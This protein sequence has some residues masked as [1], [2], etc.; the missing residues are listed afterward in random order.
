MLGGKELVQQFAL[1]RRA[2]IEYDV[3]PPSRGPAPHIF[4]SKGAFTFGFPAWKGGG[5]IFRSRGG[6]RMGKKKRKGT[7]APTQV[8]KA[9]GVGT[10]F[11]IWVMGACARLL[12]KPPLFEK[13][14]HWDYSPSNQASSPLGRPSWAIW[15][16]LNRRELASYLSNLNYT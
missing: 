10:I 11:A 14:H 16:F 12:N 15:I 8:G 9:L 5:K 13:V 6:N 1:V 4:H 3:V 7:I 2:I